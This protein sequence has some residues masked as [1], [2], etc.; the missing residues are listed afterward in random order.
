MQTKLSQDA[1]ISSSNW[2]LWLDSIVKNPHQHNRLTQVG[3]KVYY[4]SA[5]ERTLCQKNGYP[6]HILTLNKIIQITQAIYWQSSME[7]RDK[8]QILAGIDYIHQQRQMRYDQLFCLVKW[9][10]KLIGVEAQLKAEKEAIEKLKKEL[11]QNLFVL[12]N[13]INEPEN[14]NLSALILIQ[15]EFNQLFQQK[16]QLKDEEKSKWYEDCF[17]FE[18]KLHEFKLSC[19]ADYLQ[20]LK[21]ELK[22]IDKSLK[23]G[24]GEMP[25]FK[26]LVKVFGNE[27]IKPT[28]QATLSSLYAN[29]QL[30]NE[31]MKDDQVGELEAYALHAKCWI[32]SERTGL[33]LALLTA[34][35]K[36]W[37]ERQKSQGEA[38]IQLVEGKPVI[39][40]PRD[41]EIYL[42]EDYLDRG[43]YKIVHTIT[44]LHSARKTLDR[45][46][47]V[48]LQYESA[49]LEAESEK[50]PQLS[51]KNSVIL[52]ERKETGVLENSLK[53]E[54]GTTRISEQPSQSSDE[55]GEGSF[56]AKSTNF[57]SRPPSMS[58][59][60]KKKQAAEEDAEYRIEAS[61]CWQY[62]NLPGVWPTLNLIEV[63]GHMAMIQPIAGYTLETI[64]GE[65][66][67]ALSFADMCRLSRKKELK[68][69]DQLVFLTMIHHFLIG[70]ASLHNLGI[71]HRD[72]KPANILCSQE[73]KAAVTDLGLICP[74]KI[75]STESGDKDEKKW[76]SN[77]KKKDI[78]G[79]PS[80]FS[81]EMWVYNQSESSLE[82][83]FAV[84]IWSAGLILWEALSGKKRADHPI[85]EGVS[86]KDED[87]DQRIQMI[88]A[89]LSDQAK[90]SAYQSS[91]PKPNENSL[92]HLVWRCTR[93]NPKE[94]PP[95]SEV[96]QFY[97]KWVL[98][99]TQIMNRNEIQNLSECFDI[100]L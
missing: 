32:K 20:E 40:I 43:S 38:T 76:I 14:H 89:L 60:K 57:I 70:V 5:E 91:Y 97:E 28:L 93:A 30:S 100:T 73:G 50:S 62:R 95:I 90:F 46:K 55:E 68:K 87:E 86:N 80:Y 7:C 44:P 74:D 9:F 72:L 79:T 37:R 1:S 19:S 31:E 17:I 65:E 3:D 25:R 88:G 81:P 35:E 29:Q 98:A 56:I 2:T 83:D 66:K 33:P 58:E 61:C 8:N 64:R 63:G 78:V 71:I 36:I 34:I 11:I 18:K 15:N 26:T 75:P 4:L 77:P 41:K 59:L 6:V 47:L 94:R 51:Q 10:A 67:I 84:D 16:N 52:S 23:E 39:F 42:Y 24:N 85:F 69:E 54:E 27:V 82:I 12:D 99:V 48:I 13:E 21:S 22:K 49:L 92:A 96:I 53:D 45:R